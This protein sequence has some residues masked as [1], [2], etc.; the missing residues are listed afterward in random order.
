MSRSYYKEVGIDFRNSDL[1]LQ[2]ACR[3]IIHK[4][5]ESNVHDA[6]E[7][8]KLA[9]ELYQALESGNVSLEP[10]NDKC[11]KYYSEDIT[12]LNNQDSNFQDNYIDAVVGNPTFDN[13][14]R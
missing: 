8:A 3:K 2:G 11:C 12:K 13:I 9:A 5:R 7:D 10:N 1:S 6:E 14:M 4:Q